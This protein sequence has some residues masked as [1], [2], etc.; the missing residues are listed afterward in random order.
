MKDITESDTSALYL[1]I[2]LDSHPRG[3]VVRVATEI[4]DDLCVV[5]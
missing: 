5:G 3:A 1:D 2:L 4:S